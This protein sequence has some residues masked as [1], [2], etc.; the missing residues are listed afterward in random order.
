MR[1]G[2]R[3]NVITI[4]QATD[5][6]RDALRQPVKAWAAFKTD[7]FC[8]IIPA[9]GGETFDAGGKQ[10]VATGLWRFRC[11]FYDVQGVVAKMRINFEG[12]FYNIV[13]VTPDHQCREDCIISA[14]LQDGQA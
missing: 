10:R 2:D 12:Q 5:G 14:E 7:I 1:N 13:D 9:R 4:E 11:A 3:K 8:A 6:A